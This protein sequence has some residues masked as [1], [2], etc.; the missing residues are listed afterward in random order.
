[1]GETGPGGTQDDADDNNGDM[2]K[3]FGFYPT[4][5]LGSTVWVDNMAG[6]N[7]TDNDGIQNNGETGLA[8]VTVQLFSI[9]PDG[10]KGTADDVQINVGPDGMLGTADDAAGGMLTNAMGNY[11]FSNLA[12]GKY[13]V[14]L[15]SS[16]FAAAGAAAAYQLSSTPTDADDNRR[17][18][19]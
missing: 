7:A 4:L 2:T 9:G 16:N 8:G 11:Y 3:D 19:R 12:P 15:P 17:R 13:Y 6:L 14:V 1:L 18:R 5:S 10:V